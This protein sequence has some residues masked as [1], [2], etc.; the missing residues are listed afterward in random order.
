M[1]RHERRATLSQALGKLMSRFSVEIAAITELP[2]TD[3]ESIR[4]APITASSPVKRAPTLT[5]HLKG[6]NRSSAPP[7]A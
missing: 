7:I 6:S 3:A 5:D 1:N 2:S 4:T